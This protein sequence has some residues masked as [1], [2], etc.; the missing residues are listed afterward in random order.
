MVESTLGGADSV[1]LGIDAV[2]RGVSCHATGPRKYIGCTTSKVNTLYFT[3]L[4]NMFRTLKSFG[5]GILP[6]AEIADLNSLLKAGA[7]S[8]DED[9]PC[10]PLV[11]EIINCVP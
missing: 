10:D 9:H 7:G 8:L 2:Y 5:V 3:S 1:Y 11:E 4:F 6:L